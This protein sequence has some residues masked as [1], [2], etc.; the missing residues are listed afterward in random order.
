M[1]DHQKCGRTP[2][3]RSFPFARLP[4]LR[5]LERLHRRNE[6]LIESHHPLRETLIL[7]TGGSEPARRA[8]LQRAYHC[9]KELLVQNWRPRYEN[10]PA[11]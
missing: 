1:T 2:L 11:F 6:F 9:S 3:T 4:E 5:Q 10:A 7:Q 8:F